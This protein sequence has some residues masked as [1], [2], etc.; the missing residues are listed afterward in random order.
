MPLIIHLV[1]GNTIQPRFSQEE[2]AAFVQAFQKYLAG[3]LQTNGTDAL[4]GCRFHLTGDSPSYMIINF[5]HVTHILENP[6][7]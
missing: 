7:E 4:A 2:D 3:T 1:H 5:A 6:V